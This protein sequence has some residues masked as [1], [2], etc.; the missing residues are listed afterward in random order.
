MHDGHYS[1]IRD[2]LRTLRKRL[3]DLE[4]KQ[5][6]S[7]D[8]TRLSVHRSYPKRLI[9]AVVSLAT[10]LGGGSLLWS[11]E[12]KALF[13]DNAGNVRIQGAVG[14]HRAPIANQS[15][16]IGASKGFI[17]FNVASESENWLTFLEDGQVRMNGGNVGIARGLTVNGDVK[18]NG[19]SVNIGKALTVS[20]NATIKNAF[21][22]DVG[23]GNEWVGFASSGSATR[24]GYALLQSTDGKNTFLN[25]EPGN[26]RIG[27]R[28]GNTDKMVVLNNGNV[29]IGT[30]S[31]G[32]ALEVNGVIKG[33]P[34]ISPQVY[35]VVRVNGPQAYVGSGSV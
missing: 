19:S 4:T 22:G 3:E 12:I 29:G 21:V 35:V 32:V 31:P 1:E 6:V 5:A 28:V 14:I 20:G 8:S 13:I 23:H 10:L 17:P 9:V 18:M 33:K 30:P 24:T 16:L 34:W 27:F 7:R 15:L 2:E 26:G 11:D 25:I